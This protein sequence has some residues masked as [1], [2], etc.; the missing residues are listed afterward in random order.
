MA[1]RARVARIWLASWTKSATRLI[2][3]NGKFGIEGKIDMDGYILDKDGNPKKATR[4][5]RIAWWGHPKRNEWRQ[6]SY[7]KIGDCAIS[8]VFLMFDHNDYDTG[9]PLIFETMVLSGP[10]EGKFKRYST[11]ASALIGHE[12]VVA[13]EQ[14]A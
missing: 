6:I 7:T 14:G 11:K 5:E 10:R 4:A 8:T 13:K 9:P 1:K 12:Q 2:A 3:A